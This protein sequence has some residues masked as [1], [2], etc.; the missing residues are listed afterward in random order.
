[1]KTA[2]LVI[3]FIWIVALQAQLNTV[4]SKLDEAYNMAD[5]ASYGVDVTSGRIDDVCQILNG[6]C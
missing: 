6:R 1:M 3:A 5:D 4:Q 2:L